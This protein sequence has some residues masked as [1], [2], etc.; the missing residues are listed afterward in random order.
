MNQSRKG[1]LVAEALG[2]ALFGAIFGTVCFYAIAFFVVYTEFALVGAALMAALG[3][4][5]LSR[6]QRILTGPWKSPLLLP[7]VLGTFSGGI[8]GIVLVWFEVPVSRLLTLLL[9]GAL[10]G[11]VA[12]VVA[13]I[14][15]KSAN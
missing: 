12:S 11:G 7:T 14:W 9:V 15:K 10:A 1:G 2:C 5:I 3:V 6:Y 8:V 4:S 13:G